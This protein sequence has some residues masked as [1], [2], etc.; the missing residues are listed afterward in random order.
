ALER[1]GDHAGWLE[2]RERQGPRRELAAVDPRYG[3]GGV[4]PKPPVQQGMCHL[5]PDNVVRAERIRLAR[6]D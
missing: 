3:P 2:V 5:H 6:Y 1:A 4:R